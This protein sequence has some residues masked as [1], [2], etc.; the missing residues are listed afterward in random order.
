[1][2]DTIAAEATPKGRGGVGIVRLSGVKA[3]AI[4][5]QMTRQQL[6]PRY[7][8]FCSFLDAQGEV[9]DQGIALFFKGPNSFT[10][11]DVVELQCHGGPV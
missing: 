8:E 1:M 4:A 10:G 11:E 6:K 9:V 2:N 5:L 3:L 7:A